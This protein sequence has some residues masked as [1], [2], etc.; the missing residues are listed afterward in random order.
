MKARHRLEHEILKSWT[1]SQEKKWTRVELP[2]F[3]VAVSGGL[4]S[5][6]LLHALSKV[7]DNKLIHV[8]HFHHGDSQN[9]NIQVFRDE[10]QRIVKEFCLKKNITFKTQKSAQELRSEDEFRKARITFFRDY[11]Q[12][13]RDIV[14]LT[15]H[16]KDDILENQLI[17]LIRGTSEKG[18][19]S[20]FEWNAKSVVGVPAWRP[21]VTVSR[22]EIV[23]YASAHNVNW[24]EDPSNRET[25]YLRN[26]IRHF[27]LV[28]LEAF[29]PGSK[30]A[31]ARSLN[32]LSIQKGR[33][34]DDE[35]EYSDFS[36]LRWKVLSEEKK[37]RSLARWL[38]ESGIETITSGQLN[39]IAR[40]LKSCEGH[41]NIHFKTFDIQINAG[42]VK[43]KIK[44]S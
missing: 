28:E 36:L 20:A 25:F 33:D 34:D 39:E 5:M 17:K 22:K 1:R 12:N 23:S 7:A 29:R 24:E 3:V 43:I 18:L 11:V 2:N 6:A 41:D 40:R 21:W 26:W 10:A 37:M 14:F 44:V 32:L 8:L 30:D 42:Q 9:G 15:G 38:V 19:S 13:R 27:W 4:D 35:N 31:L 16:H